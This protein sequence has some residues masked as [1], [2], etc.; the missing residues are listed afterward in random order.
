MMRVKIILGYLIAFISSVLLSTII[1]LLALKG[2]V[3][4]KN[5]VKVIL[6]EKNYYELVSKEIREEMEDYITSSGFDND[7]LDDIYTYEEVLEDINLFV[8]NAYI[9][10]VTSLDKKNILEKLDSNIDNNLKS[11]NLE[12]VNREDISSFEEDIKDIYIKE[13]TLYGMTNNIIL[14]L[15]TLNSYINKMII[16]LSVIL[17]IL[18]S[19]LIII[20]KF[21][22]FASSIIASALII[23][24]LY[25]AV[26]ENIDSNNLLLITENFSLILSCIIRNIGSLLLKISIISILIGIIFSLTNACKAKKNKC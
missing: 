18:F 2:T 1:I 16:I 19:L 24:F 4:N 22:L 14:K 11:S 13:I 10:K 25:I 6:Q 23:L 7:I 20:K 17:V 9:G 21:F 5:Y 12:V 8:D 15:N 3:G 26:Y